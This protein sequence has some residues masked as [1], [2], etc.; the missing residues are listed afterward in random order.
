VELCQV[1]A[2]PSAA[3]DSGGLVRIS[4][5]SYEPMAAALKH[6]F[7]VGD[8]RK[9]SPHPFFRDDRFEFVLCVYEAGDDGRCHWHADVAEYN[10]ILSGRL[11]CLEVATGET[12]WYGPGDFV[13]IPAGCCVKRL[14]PEP[15]RAV[16]IKVPSL[17][18]DKIECR[19]CDRQCAFRVEPF[20]QERA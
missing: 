8:L 13:H 15:T 16:T 4:P 7:L 17:P 9:P 3:L 2:D 1:P 20:Q 6:V 5:E 19:A 18:G 12:H 14:V 10:F 11:G